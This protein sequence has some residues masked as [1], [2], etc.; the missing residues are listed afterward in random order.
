MALRRTAEL[1]SSSAVCPL[2]SSFI[3]TFALLLY[4]DEPPLS[5]PNNPSTDCEDG[6]YVPAPGWMEL[7]GSRL[8]G[9]CPYTVVEDELIHSPYRCLTLTPP[10]HP[11]Q[12]CLARRRPAGETRRSV[13]DHR[14]RRR[15]GEHA[16]RVRLRRPAQHVQGRG[17]GRGRG[18]R[19]RRRR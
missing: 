6:K 15:Q 9:R 3:Y 5:P 2:G 16:Q 1:H 12:L 17:R 18:R 19:G 10:L 11:R 7:L 13:R 14:L 4:L 8:W